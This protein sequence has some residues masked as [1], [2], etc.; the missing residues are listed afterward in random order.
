MY[1]LMKNQPKLVT[2]TRTPSTEKKYKLVA[3]FD[4]GTRVTFGAK[5]CMDF[6]L[7]H[8]RDGLHVAAKKR[9]AYIARHRV[10]EDWNDPTSRGAL[11]RFILWEYP[12][13]EEATKKYFRPKKNH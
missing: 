7:Y 5:G 11:S 9:K 10:R 13:L 3:T 8:A 12:T 1:Q 6:T 2:V 4:D